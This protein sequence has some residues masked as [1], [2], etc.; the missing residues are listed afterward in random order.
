MSA[1]LSLVTER[2]SRTPV[3]G[4]TSRPLALV[5]AMIVAASSI[6][7]LAYWDEQRESASALKD[8]AEE[9]ARLAQSL[10]ASLALRLDEIRRAE[11]G[12]LHLELAMPQL[13]AG[14]SGIER[15]RG[16]VL[17]VLPPRQTDFWTSDGRRIA[18]DNIRI[19]L[20][21]GQTSLRIERT[22]AQ[23]LG[24]HRRT[25][26][27]GLARVDAS[28]LG[29]WGI[30][31]VASAE[32]ERDR[33]KWAQWRLLLAVVVAGGLVFAFG[34]IALHIQRKEL[35][36]ERELAISD[37]ERQQ[38]EHLARASKAATMGTLAMGIAHEIGTPLGIIV[39]RAEQLLAK[40][41][42]DERA[43]ASVHT[44]I[45]E[46]ERIAQVTRGFLE[47]ARGD[48]PTT[49]SI[50]PATVVEGAL[51]L[52]EHRFAKAGIQLT[53][54]ISPDLPA[55]HGD[56]RLLEHALI[57]LLLN[58]CDACERGGHV[59]VVARSPGDAVVFSVADDGVGISPAN[60]VRVTEPFFTTKVSGHGT[61]LGL[62]VAN[63]IVK[64]H[65]GTLV[66]AAR[67]PRGT[68]AVIELPLTGSA[69]E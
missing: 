61:G 24:L 54:D 31:T 56:L 48:G 21:T 68:R 10:A 64:S 23:Q 66:I 67:Q 52:V 60:L 11:H 12:T 20:E 27:A 28:S 45:T 15:P 35:I 7:A 38:D 30:A 42:T 1:G 3:G 62:A 4:R 14:I 37:L 34:G 29:V 32:R 19:A 55:V 50:S 58:A 49:R 5:I 47:L 26:V 69:I 13:M 51:A 2:K 22:A 63:E 43:S 36:L 6:A 8:F 39:G 41:K 25:A 44:I 46:A 9:Q 65:R 57:N 53:A 18:A 16:L 40:V 59:E 33:E 17:L